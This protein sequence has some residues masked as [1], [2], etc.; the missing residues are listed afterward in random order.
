MNTGEY[1][2]LELLRSFAVLCVVVCHV[3]N[4]FVVNNSV[5]VLGIFGVTLF[6]VHTSIVLMQSLERQQQDNLCVPFFI[7]RFFRIYPLATLTAT[8]SNAKTASQ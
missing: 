5:Q 6:F 4:F 1:S 2:N 7:R 8:H 3:G